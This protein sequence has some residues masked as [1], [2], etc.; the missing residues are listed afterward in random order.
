MKWVLPNRAPTTTQLNPPPPS[1]TL[2]V[3]KNQNIARSWSV[4]PNLG[5]KIQSQPILLKI[6][7]RN[8]LEVLIPNPELHF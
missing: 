2:N 4:S 5:Q 3:T 1:S 6:N 8:I 7:T